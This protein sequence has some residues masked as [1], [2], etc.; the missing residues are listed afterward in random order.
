MK[1]DIDV[2][3]IGGGA[4]GVCSAYYLAE[5]GL[6]VSVVEQGEIASGCS[7]AN[8][9]LIVP[10]HCVPMASPGAL[11]LGLKGMLKP[12]SPFYVKLRFD[13]ALFY[14][15]R[16]FRKACNSE[17]MHRG[18]RVLHD[19]GWASIELFN[20]LLEDKTLEC[21]YR[22]EGWLLTYKTEKGFKQAQE[23]ARLLEP[24]NIKS[25]ILSADETLEM[26]PTLH[27][28]ISGGIYF[29]EDV[30]LDPEK[31]V[32]ALAKRLREQG[33]TIITQAEVI[34]LKTS[35]QLVTNVR[36]TRGDFQPKKVVLAAGAWAPDLAKSLGFRLPVQPAKG[37]SISMK[38]PK[39]CPRL[40]LYLSEAKV[41]VTPLE[42]ELRL[43]GTLEL[44][45][46]DFKLNLRRVNAIMR[47]A[48]YYLEQ[49]ESKDIIK[50]NQGLRP[51]TPDGLPIIDRFPG[52]SNLF[53]AT[54]HGMLGITLAPITGRLV[55]Q[56][57]CKQ[58]PDVYLAPVSVTRFM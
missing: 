6:R 43:A 37:Y 12:K 3:V 52:Y 22:Q 4:I 14:W 49:A 31:F 1:N 8:A 36:T 33:I 25:K 23:E 17:Q 40:P 16:R 47:A 26:E 2:L 18:I 10:S 51:C 28:P 20:D 19:L 55:S 29:P 42:D 53:V 9:G 35:Q 50:I 30:H 32:Q 41:A 27:P 46:M 34:E 54:G 15:L 21:N 45:G 5:Q 48:K 24:Y 57:V 11:S 13:P 39:S 44:A 58:T 7:G 56:L 38:C